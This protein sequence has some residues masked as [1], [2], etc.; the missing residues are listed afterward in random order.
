MRFRYLA[1]RLANALAQFFHH[2]STHVFLW[3]LTSKLRLIFQ[4]LPPDVI[5]EK[6]IDSLF[7]E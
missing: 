2:I 7:D 3:K 5:G 1:V 4:H 6:G